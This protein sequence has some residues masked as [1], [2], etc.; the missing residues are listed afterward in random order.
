MA[1]EKTWIDNRELYII[2]EYPVAANNR[3]SILKFFEDNK[4]Y[5]KDELAKAARRSSVTI[6]K[7][8][9]KS[10]IRGKKSQFATPKV[11]RI[12]KEYEKVTDPT[13]WDNREWFY[14]KYVDEKL[15]IEAIAKIIERKPLIVF[16]RLKRYK[17]ERRQENN[18]STNACCNEKW[19]MYHYATPAEYRKWCQT[20]AT[21]YDKS[22]GKCLSQRQCAALAGVKQFTI[23]NWLVKF[24]I[25]I[26][27]MPQATAF[28]YRR[29]NG[30]LG[31]QEGSP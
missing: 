24:N 29:R 23:Y 21:D 4:Y 5:H 13:I 14:Q 30:L 10:G 18:P 19:L 2:K 26:R 31:N 17:I 16:R 20:N 9:Q 22:G 15:G 28:G 6:D 7:W 27:D 12:P 8:S 1:Q 11:K 3:L 25:P